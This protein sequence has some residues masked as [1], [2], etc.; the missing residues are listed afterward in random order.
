VPMARSTRS[1]LAGYA[2]NPN[3]GDLAGARTIGVIIRFHP[4]GANP[5]NPHSA[6]FSMDNVVQK[7]NGTTSRERAVHPLNSWSVH[8]ASNLGA[9][10]SVYLSAA[11]GMAQYYYVVNNA[12]GQLQIQ[13]RPPVSPQCASGGCW[14]P[15]HPADQFFV[16]CNL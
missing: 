13:N 11:G 15:A 16:A 4:Q 6:T 10:A 2:E 5:N 9:V 3:L 14:P 7:K 1:R 8:D 12:Q